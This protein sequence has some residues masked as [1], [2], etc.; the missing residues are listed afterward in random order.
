MRLDVSDDIQSASAVPRIKGVIASQ[1]KADTSRHRPRRS[2]KME[3][4]NGRSSKVPSAWAEPSPPTFHWNAGHLNKEY[5]RL[6]LQA[7]AQK[8]AKRRGRQPRTLSAEITL[9]LFFPLSG[10]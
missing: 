10:L 8:S 1:L 6:A 9:H 3:L 4:R 5:G 2:A 7:I